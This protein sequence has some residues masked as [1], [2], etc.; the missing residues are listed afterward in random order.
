MKK[1]CLP[2]KWLILCLAWMPCSELVAQFSLSAEV[3]PRAEYRHGFKKLF[4]SAT[5]DPAFFVE[6][7]SRLKIDYRAEKFDLYVSMQDVRIWGA[8]RQ[9][10]KPDPAIAHSFFAVHEAW[11]RYRFTPNT[12]LKLGRQELEYDN[13]RFLGNLD[14]AQQARSHDAAVLVVRDSTRQ[15]HVG[16]AFN[17]D[18][19]TPE[20]G[21]L[22]GTFYDQTG[23]YKTMQYAWYHKDFSH[24]RLSA[25][26]FNNG[27]QA[28]DSSVQFSQ[29]FG[30]LG[31]AETGG[32]KLGAE[33]YYQTGKD[34]A[35]NDLSA[36]LFSATAG[37]Q[38]GKLGLTLGGDYVSG[39]ALS[40]EAG[41][42]H[43]FTPLYGTNH[44]FYG[45]MDY[46]YVGNGHAQAGKTVGLIDPFVKAQIGLGKKTTLM[47]HAHYFLSPVT[48]YQNP[49]SLTGELPA[50]LGTEIDL[51][52]KTRMAPGVVLEG[53]YSQLFATETMQALKGGSPA[54]MQNWAWLMIS[55]SPTLFTTEK[56]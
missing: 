48:I 4:D 7:R 24:G 1:R 16:A 27:V 53:G 13:A 50:Y 54:A 26:A 15:L 3:R 29:T 32:V 31:S 18:A 2:L 51:V 17:Q 30:L 10:Y 21:K 35:G 12:S 46:F 44:K 11:G 22:L 19:N 33:A 55:F 40:A 45:L 43:S 49:E 41:S 52:F 28:A 39:T 25:L 9:M 14:W 23:N 36:Y 38:I 5:D 47:A 37:F 8:D 42:S 6:Q 56:N 20:Y 34:E